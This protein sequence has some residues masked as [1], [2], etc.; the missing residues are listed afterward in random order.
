MADYQSLLTRAVANLPPSS[1]PAARQAIYGRARK[2]LVT[3]LR[4]LRPPLP[5]NDIGARR[6]R[7]TRRSRRSRRNE[8]RSAGGRAAGRGSRAAEPSAAACANGLNRVPTL[9]HARPTVQKPA[10]APRLRPPADASARR[11]PQPP[12]RARAVVGRPPEFRPIPARP[13]PLRLRLRSGGAAT[14][15]RPAVPPHRRNSKPPPVQVGRRARRRRP[16]RQ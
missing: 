7:S 6:P 8:R 2:A 13:S 11:E 9:R 10:V 3:Q 12:P 1:T 5:E 15:P 16:R 4:S 14:S